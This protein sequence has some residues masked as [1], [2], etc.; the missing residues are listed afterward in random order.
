MPSPSKPSL[1]G[2]L[3]QHMRQH[4]TLSCPTPPSSRIVD[5]FPVN[6]L[7][8]RSSLCPSPGDAVPFIWTNGYP[9]QRYLPT[10]LYSLF[11]HPAQDAGEKRRY[12]AMLSDRNADVPRALARDVCHRAAWWILRSL[13]PAR[14][15]LPIIKRKGIHRFETGI[16]VNE[17][18]DLR[19][20]PR[21]FSREPS[22]LFP[23]SVGLGVVERVGIDEV[24]EVVVRIPPEVGERAV[25]GQL[26]VRCAD[27]PPQ[28][29]GDLIAFR[30]RGIVGADAR[31]RGE[32][33]VTR[34]PDGVEEG[35]MWVPLVLLILACWQAFAQLEA[36]IDLNA[37][38]YGG[39]LDPHV[40]DLRVY[41]NTN[42][43]NHGD[44]NNTYQQVINGTNF[45]SIASSIA[46]PMSH[47]THLHIIFRFS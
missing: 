29:P 15:H 32:F 24:Q 27:E 1:D 38:D 26:D 10:R 16:K 40:A 36:Q 34:A 37:Q 7:Q 39:Q 46:H 19:A 6:S 12:I 42:P 41:S 23:L 44:N 3:R 18:R 35:V 21:G 31:S 11:P 14:R 45:T 13:A 5:I 33:K 2:R 28:S 25:F 22:P 43:S 17:F 9:S 8:I 47:R 30:T 4:I 20:N